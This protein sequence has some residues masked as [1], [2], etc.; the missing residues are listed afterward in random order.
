MPNEFFWKLRELQGVDNSR[1]TAEAETVE[2]IADK[3]KRDIEIF[4]KMNPFSRSFLIYP[5]RFFDQINQDVS[6][7][8]ENRFYELFAVAVHKLYGDHRFGLQI[9]LFNDSS[10]TTVTTLDLG[11]S[12]IE[13][14]VTR[15][16]FSWET[17]RNHSTDLSGESKRRECHT[18]IS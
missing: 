9:Y 12:I 1:D 14:L 11:R 16:E 15:I 10:T 18:R 2:K 4:A 7:V 17:A 3:I 8:E 13:N 6:D 5:G